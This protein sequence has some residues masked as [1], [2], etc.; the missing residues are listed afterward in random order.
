MVASLE[1]VCAGLRPAS[2]SS[3]YVPVQRISRLDA[4]SSLYACS[5]EGRQNQVYN[6]LPEDQRVFLSALFTTTRIR[7]CHGWVRL[8]GETIAHLNR[9]SEIDE[10]RARKGDLVPTYF[11]PGKYYFGLVYEYI[12][13]AKLEV[14]AVQRQIDFLHYAGFTTCQP[15]NKANWQG[16]GIKLDF[17]DYRTPSIRTLRAALTTCHQPKL[18]TFWTCRIRHPIRHHRS[19]GKRRRKPIVDWTGSRLSQRLWNADTLCVVLRNWEGKKPPPVDWKGKGTP[20][21]HAT[22]STRT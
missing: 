11:K 8:S 13:P 3:V 16:P 4:L 17:G 21:V 19:R 14:D 22:V 7:R 10:R 15:A 2:S 5:V 18:G 12:P 6:E 1:Q 9:Y 20:M